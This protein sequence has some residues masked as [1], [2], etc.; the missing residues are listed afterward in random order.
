MQIGCRSHEENF[1]D[2]VDIDEDLEK[3]PP[4]TFEKRDKSINSNKGRAPTS[5]MR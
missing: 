3:H 4:V 2:D 5:F 1:E